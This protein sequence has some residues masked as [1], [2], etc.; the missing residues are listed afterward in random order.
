[1]KAFTRRM[2]QYAAVLTGICLL[3]TLGVAG[4]YYLTKTKI[5]EKEREMREQAQRAAIPAA[6]VQLSFEPVETPVRSLK[7][8]VVRA[9]DDAGKVY[10][11][12]AMGA[13]QGYKSKVRVMVGMDPEAE[14]I[15]GMA[16]V[17]QQETP[18][19]GTQIAEVEPNQTIVGLVTGQPPTKREVMPWFLKRFIGRTKDEL[20]LRS[21]GGGPGV[22]GITGATISSGAVVDAAREAVTKIRQAI[23]KEPAPD[24][25][26]GD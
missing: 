4:T 7:D 10:G 13:A 26:T 23:G 12:T 19:L 2:V 22:D 15:I 6:A 20:R 24:A 25:P 9:V 14:R 21:S 3:A 8:E 18:G 1:V 17:S 5:E 16:V 11:Y